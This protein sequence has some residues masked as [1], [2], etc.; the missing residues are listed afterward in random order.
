MSLNPRQVVGRLRRFR[1]HRASFEPLEARQLLTASPV[2]LADLGGPGSSGPSN[3]ADVGGVTYFQADDGIH[4]AELWRSDGTAAGTYLARD[5]DPGSWGSKPGELVNVDGTLYFAATTHDLGTELWKSDGTTEGTVPVADIV[6]GVAGSSPRNLTAVGNVLFFEAGD[7]SNDWE[8]WR[9]DGSAAGTYRVK[10]LNTNGSSFPGHFTNVNGVLFFEASDGFFGR[11]L[12]KSDGTAAGTVVVGNAS[13]YKNQRPL[14]LTNVDGTLYFTAYSNDSTRRLWTSDGTSAGTHSISAYAY[15]TNL[16]NFAGALYFGIASTLY[17]ANSP[18]DIQQIAEL[19]PG[20]GS[21]A[22]AS[23]TPVGN[24]LFFAG[25]TTADGKELW[26]TDGTTPGT[27]MVADL[28]PGPDGV[29][30]NNLA[31]VG[32][33]LY[34]TISDSYESLGGSELW[35][36]DGTALGTVRVKDIWPGPDGAGP[37]N[38]TNVGGTLFFSAL[39]VASGRELWTS[40]GTELGTAQVLDIN[41]QPS[42]DSSPQSFTAAGA[43]TYFVATSLEFGA[44]LWKT[45]G[46]TAGTVMVKDIRPGRDSSGAARLTAVDGTLFFFANDGSGY[47]LW[48]SD[49]TDE[50]TQPVPYDW[51]SAFDPTTALVNANGTLYFG[52]RDENADYRLWTSDG[53]ATGTH[54]VAGTQPLVP[55]TNSQTTWANHLVNIGSDL[56]YVAVNA[57]DNLRQELWKYDI[58]S[59]TEQKLADLSEVQTQYAEY[60]LVNVS[61]TLFFSVRSASGAYNLWKTDGTPEGTQAL[62]DIA[63][64]QGATPANVNGRLFFAASDADSGVELWTSDGTPE[65]TV[66]VDDLVPGSGSVYPGGLTAVGDTLFFVSREPP[67]S[68]SPLWKSNGT[69]AGTMRVNAPDIYNMTGLTNVS[70]ALYFLAQRSGA[71][72]ELWTSDGTSAGTG[73]VGTV[74]PTSSSSLANVNGMLFFAGND[75]VHGAEPFIVAPP[76]VARLFY[77]NSSF[78]GNTPAAGASDDAALAI[79]KLPYL[80]GSGRAGTNNVSSYYQGIN[81][82]FVDLAGPHGEI[83]ADDFTF[84]IGNSNAPDTWIAAPSPVSIAV[85]PGAGVAG[86]DR[87]ELIW[88]DGAIQNIWLQVTVRGNDAAGGFDTNTG[89]AASDVF[90]F[91]NRIGDTFVATPDAVLVTNAGDEVGARTHLGFMQPITNVYDFNKDGQVNASDMIIARLN[92]G[93]LY[94]IE[95]PNPTPLVQA[96]AVTADSGTSQIAFA[97]AARDHAVGQ[98]NSKAGDERLMQL[99]LCDFLAATRSQRSFAAMAPARLWL[100]SLADLSQDAGELSGTSEELDD[101]LLES[102][103]VGPVE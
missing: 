19:N 13:N 48:R 66:R 61:G 9:S 63:M 26:V 2:L 70:G 59:A 5:I 91:G 21:S 57:N 32:D 90:Y 46:T 103:A 77:N 79:D 25:A 23:L 36:S 50:G 27:H 54:V 92:T 53:T 30:P 86:S 8:L 76:V 6:P 89:L 84:K 98:Q 72:D 24:Q 60:N 80:P 81:G 41:Q 20:I 42:A 62:S 97:L 22:F 58:V 65:G 17:R 11:D 10:D 12:W 75:G 55:W 87:V 18:T 38:L 94:R 93:Y 85:R 1:F 101:W 47:A 99:G 15:P 43:I 73:Q 35:K 51:T 71:L 44:E 96:A 78:D 49:G 68:G 39:D 14:F 88:A 95:L 28:V 37:N 74:Q 29:L 82:L 4:G 31:A 3:L 56:Y 67:G 45:D 7:A 52:L 64:W 16:T 102:I 100:A 69:A 40:D 83:T 34:F 33:T